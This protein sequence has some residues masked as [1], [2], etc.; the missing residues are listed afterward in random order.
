MIT[1]PK[2]IRKSILVFFWFFTFGLLTVLF[3]PQSAR[4]DLHSENYGWMRDHQAPNSAVN[5]A[6]F[7]VYDAHTHAPLQADWLYVGVQDMTANTDNRSNI[8]TTAPCPASVTI[9]GFTNSLRHTWVGVGKTGYNMQINEQAANRTYTGGT[10]WIYDIYVTLTSDPPQDQVINAGED[11]LYHINY[12]PPGIVTAKN[13]PSFDAGAST[14]N[15]LVR[16]GSYTTFPSWTTVSSRTASPPFPTIF[17]FNLPAGMSDGWIYT[18]TCSSDNSGA[19]SGCSQVGQIKDTVAPTTT[20][21][22]SNSGTTINVH[23]TAIDDSNTAP[24]GSQNA[25]VLDGALEMSTDGGATWSL[26][27]TVI[28]YITFPYAN[29]DPIDEVITV[30]GDYS[31]TYTFRWRARDGSRNQ[32][33]TFTQ[34]SN[35]C[36]TAALTTPSAPLASP[37]IINGGVFVGASG[38]LNLHRRVSDSATTPAERIDYNLKALVTL[39]NIIP[40]LGTTGIVFTEVKP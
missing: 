30:N 25:R 17:T 5:T 8:C 20:C 39:P 28:N 24:G 23:V 6:I 27:T 22:A 9:S 1:S 12:V 37:L 31:K 36:S 40:Q 4:A 26:V 16:F 34:Y 15:S 21:S 11:F 7:N 13:N 32:S 18:E 19:Y 3:F 29:T 38:V 14:L 2:I 33:G 10:T 35:Y